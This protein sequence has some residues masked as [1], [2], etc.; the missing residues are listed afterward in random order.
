MRKSRKDI[1]VFLTNL[2]NDTVMNKIAAD[3][4]CFDDNDKNQLQV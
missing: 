4:L 3:N 1:Y 2:A